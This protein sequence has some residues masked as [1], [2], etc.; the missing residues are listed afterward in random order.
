MRNLIPFMVLLAALA[1]CRRSRDAGM[2]FVDP[3][4]LTLVPPGTTALAGIRVDT[5]TK[6]PLYQKRLAQ[7]SLPGIGEFVEATGVDPR[8]DIWQVLAAMDGKSTVI[9]IR[10]KFSEGGIEPRLKI[11]GASRTSHKGY[12][13]TGSETFGVAFLN[14]TTAVAGRPEAVKAVL[15]NRERSG[16]SPALMGQLR[17][18][19]HATHMWVVLNGGFP[20]PRSGG[21]R[22]GNWANIEKFAAGLQSLTASADFSNGLTVRLHGVA[23]GEQE[24]KQLAAAMKGLIGLGRLSTPS[25]RPQLLRAFDALKVAQEGPQVRLDA[26]LEEPLAEQLLDFVQSGATS[27]RLPLGN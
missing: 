9:M 20:L 14:P 15:D 12:T 22:E 7:S 17:T 4:L 6:T 3:A 19:P 2:V 10:G 24:A 8:R 16:P 1:G 13:I 27:K 11:P 21:A 23:T 5:L 25:D 26:S 18:I